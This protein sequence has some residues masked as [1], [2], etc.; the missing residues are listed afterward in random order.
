MTELLPGHLHA[1]DRFGHGH[2]AHALERLQKQK[3]VRFVHIHSSTR[4]G[5]I[6]M[7]W[8]GPTTE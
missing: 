1:R 7:W 5:G 4:V 3:I 8:L 2:V 6:L